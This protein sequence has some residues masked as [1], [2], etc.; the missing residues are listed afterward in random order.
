MRSPAWIGPTL[1]GLV[2]A[3]LTGCSMKPVNTL[4]PEARAAELLSARPAPLGRTCQIL[5]YPAVLPRAEELVEREALLAD[6]AAVAPPEAVAPYVLLTMGY[7]RYGINIRRAVIEHNVGAALADS[8]Q[9][10]VFKHRRTTDEAEQEWGVRLRIDLVGDPR[11][12]VGRQEVCA[13]RPRDSVLAQAITNAATFGSGT[14][15][16]DGFRESTVWVRLQVSPSGSVTGAAVE[17]GIVAGLAL[18]QRIF[19]HVRALFFEPALQ[20]G[21]PVSGSISIPVRVRER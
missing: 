9:K 4:T 10:L 17:R 12:E 1:L 2:F 14:R 3:A 13:P 19:D 5:A 7:D 16:R 11:F 6:L 20:D 15:I 21:H 18:E 8:V